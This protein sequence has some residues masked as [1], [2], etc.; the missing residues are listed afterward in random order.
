MC[1]RD[2]SKM[3][4]AKY[5]ERKAQRQADAVAAVGNPFQSSTPQ[6]TQTSTGRPQGPFPYNQTAP[7]GPRPAPAQGPRRPYSDDTQQSVTPVTRRTRSQ[8]RVRPGATRVG[9]GP[10][11]PTAPSEPQVTQRVSGGFDIS[12]PSSQGRKPYGVGRQE[13]A[14]GRPYSEMSP[15]K[16]RQLGSQQKVAINRAEVGSQRSRVAPGT[17]G[18]QGEKKVRGGAEYDA[19]GRRIREEF[20]YELLTQYIAED[21]VNAGYADDL[22]EAFDII[23]N[24]DQDTLAELVSDYLID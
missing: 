24:L 12:K 6:R 17:T 13:T 15:A 19:L 18:R 8:G 1:I 14:K 4:R 7:Q 21:I 2:R 23:E 22:Y 5:D 10:K 11:T 3:T 20:D 9:A 16:A